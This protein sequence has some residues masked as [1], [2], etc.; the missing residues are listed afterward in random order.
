MLNRRE[1]LQRIPL[2]VFG[3]AL[4]GDVAM[5]GCAVGDVV[6]NLLNLL[7]PG[8][9]GILPIIGIADPALGPALGVAIGVYDL[10]VGTVTKTYKDYEAALAANGG[11]APTLLQ[12]FKSALSTLNTDAMQILGLAHVKDPA[13]ATVVS[14]IIAAVTSEIGQIVSLFTTPV[15]MRATARTTVTVTTM[16]T[17][18]QVKAENLAFRN[19]MKAI[20]SRKTGDAELDAATAKTA[21]AYK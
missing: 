20:L 6:I 8:V 13:T 2:T 1:V 12:E 17:A 18:A 14:E 15:A 4:A 21:L 5:L 7:Q 10:A 3:L 11:T 16:P 9:D 19:R